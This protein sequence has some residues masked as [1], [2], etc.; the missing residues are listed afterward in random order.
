[1]GN[2]RWAD[3]HNAK[4]VYHAIMLLA[5]AEVYVALPEDHHDREKLRDHLLRGARNLAREIET[6]GVSTYS[7]PLR[8]FSLLATDEFAEAGLADLQPAAALAAD[9]VF[10]VILE[11]STRPDGALEPR[12][13]SVEACAAYLRLAVNGSRHEQPVPE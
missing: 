11:R 1:M 7:Q 2:G 9:R 3:G 6:S 4:S 8:M 12:Y 5:M 10:S 13:C